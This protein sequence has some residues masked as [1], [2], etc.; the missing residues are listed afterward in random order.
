MRFIKRF[1]APWRGEAILGEKKKKGKKGKKRKK[2]KSHLGHKFFSWA[3]CSNAETTFEVN[4]YSKAR[5]VSPWATSTMQEQPV[6]LGT[7]PKQE[8]YV[9]WAT[10]STQEQLLQLRVSQRPDAMWQNISLFFWKS[11]DVCI[12]RW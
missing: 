5:H 4:K 11:L 7:T 1:H 10:T 6:C 12:A 3:N 9:S 8:Q 2:E